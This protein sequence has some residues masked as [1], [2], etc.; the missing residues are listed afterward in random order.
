MS[1]IKKLISIFK[2]DDL[3]NIQTNGNKEMD[4]REIEENKHETEE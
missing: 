3:V 4:L 2:V 1:E